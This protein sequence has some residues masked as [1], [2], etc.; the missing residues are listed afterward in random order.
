MKEITF[1]ASFGDTIRTIQLSRIIGGGETWHVYVENIEVAQ[2]YIRYNGYYYEENILNAEDAQA[3][4]D[5]IME[6]LNQPYQ[7][8][9]FYYYP[10]YTEQYRERIKPLLI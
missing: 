5:R 7:R 9:V 1:E 2:I 10:V 8:I 3:I 4:L 6:Y